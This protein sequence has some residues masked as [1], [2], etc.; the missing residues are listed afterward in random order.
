MQIEKCPQDRTKRNKHE[1]LEQVAKQTPL[2]VIVC[3]EIHLLDLLGFDSQDC[4][5][6]KL[7]RC[8]LWGCV[9]SSLL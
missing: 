8:L 4:S 1:I 7:L 5:H 2:K 6:V 3:Y 9:I